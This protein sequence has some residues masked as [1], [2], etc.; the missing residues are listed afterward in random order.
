MTGT[1]P[2]APPGKAP[3]AGDAEELEKKA[4]ATAPPGATPPLGTSTQSLDQMVLDYL[5]SGE[6]PEEVELTL[7]PTPDFASGRSVQTKR[8]ATHG[9][10]ARALAAASVQVDPLPSA[11]S[12]CF[13]ARPPGRRPAGLLHGAVLPNGTAAAA[14]ASRGQRQLQIQYPIKKK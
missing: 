7:T 12:P 11:R 2:P 14:S 1:A 13:R 9:S 3:A 10:P 4:D 6:V 8:K 5:G